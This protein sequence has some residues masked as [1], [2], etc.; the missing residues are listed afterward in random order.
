MLSVLGI[1]LS[2]N[3]RITLRQLCIKDMAKIK[4]MKKE[5]QNDETS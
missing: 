1:A 3:L 5:Y 2:L 4:L